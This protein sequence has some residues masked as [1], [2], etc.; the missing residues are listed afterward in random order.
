MVGKEASK[1]AVPP[2]SW[3]AITI[4]FVVIFF[5]N[6]WYSLYVCVRLSYGYHHSQIWHINSGGCFLK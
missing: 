6:V 1:Q 5:I 3:E 2:V 4:L